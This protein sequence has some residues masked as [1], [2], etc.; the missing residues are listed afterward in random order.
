MND[1]RLAAVAF[2]LGAV[3]MLVF[4]STPTRIAG[5]LLLIGAIVLGAFAIASH[6]F[7]ADDE[8]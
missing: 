3:L 1:G 4:D 7:L 8:D 6:E 5:V 2:G